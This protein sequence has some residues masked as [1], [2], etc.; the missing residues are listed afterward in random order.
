MTELKFFKFMFSFPSGGNLKGVV[1]G[2]L[3]SDN[4][5]VTNLSDLFAVYY[6]PF[7]PPIPENKSISE[8]KCTETLPPLVFDSLNLKIED[9]PKFTLKGND[10][11]SFAGTN[12]K[13]DTFII[14]KNAQEGSILITDSSSL[15]IDCFS[16]NKEIKQFP[17]NAKNVLY[18]L[19]ITAELNQL[20]NISNTNFPTEA[21]LQG[22]LL[23]SKNINQLKRIN[24]KFTKKPEIEYPFRDFFLVFSTQNKEP[25]F[26]LI[27]NG[28]ELIF[29]AI[30]PSNTR[31]T[32]YTNPTNPSQ[33]KLNISW[34]VGYQDSDD[35]NEVFN[36]SAGKNQFLSKFKDESSQLIFY[37]KQ[38]DKEVIYEITIGELKAFSN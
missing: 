18:S 20:S 27:P 11:I 4:N 15:K 26:I 29:T 34:D 35:T 19:S 2:T 3:E 23:F 38:G 33:F 8:N 17:F 22:F 6:A 1:K 21:N 30:N 32:G 25:N 28:E 14:S 5:T 7:I 16:Q 31:G 13:G 37:D 24:K 12:K 9:N 10:P 36:S